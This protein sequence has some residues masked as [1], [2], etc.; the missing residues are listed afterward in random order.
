MFGFGV[1]ETAAAI[2]AVIQG[3]KSLND[4]LA[5]VKESAS[6]AGQ[7]TG[8]VSKYADLE[9]KIR[10]VEQ[11]KAGVLTVEESMSLQI[12][13]Q[14]SQNFHRALKDSLLVQQGGAAQYREI[15]ARIEESK[16]AHERKVA[17]LKRKRR[18]REK[19]IKEVS[20]YLT[21][22]CICIIFAL[23]GLWLWVEVFR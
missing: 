11:R 13:K 6:S 21:I 12:A 9:E 16:V 1:G 17:Q 20:L 19:L 8:L 10:D 4:A 14:Q 15:M 3:L 7:I 23:G 2:A 5:T 22:G 18:E